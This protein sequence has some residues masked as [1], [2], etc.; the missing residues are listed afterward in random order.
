MFNKAVLSLGG[1]QGDRMT[2][3]SKAL[4]LLSLETEIDKISLVYET[5]A[6]GSIAFG[7]FLNQVVEVRTNFSPQEL[8]LL[9]Q[10]IE[11]RL[12]RERN[13][14]WG[15]RTMD[16]DILDFGSQSI[17]S[18]DLTLPHPF[19]QERRFILVPLVEILPDWLHPSYGKTSRELLDEC[20]D[21]CKV[22]VFSPEET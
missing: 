15:N 19:I 6:W 2:L 13:Q 17:I 16:I 10:N 20:V 4:E 1:N 12:G 21:P 22:T 14:H 3:L 18:K 11:H 5:Q 7:D 9:V 8:L